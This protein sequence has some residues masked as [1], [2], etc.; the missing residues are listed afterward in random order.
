MVRGILFCVLV[1][2]S[3][4]T[5]PARA[6]V[7][8]GIC[9]MPWWNMEW[10]AVLLGPIAQSFVAGADRMDFVDLDIAEG[11]FG[12]EGVDLALQLRET[13]LAGAVIGTSETVALADGTNGVVRFP[14]AAPVMLEPGATYVFEI[15]RTGESG[16]A[17]VRGA[18]DDPCPAIHGWIGGT[19]SSF[20]DLWFELGRSDAVPGTARSW[21]ALKLRFEAQPD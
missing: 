9:H 5:R 16:Y 17:M 2:L 8:D 10:N 7:V 14:F 4:F 15:V 13:D 3:G 1:L 20:V 21:G 12:S 18:N 11:G 6:E 19:A